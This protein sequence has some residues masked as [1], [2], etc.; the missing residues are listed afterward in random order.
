MNDHDE[1]DPTLSRVVRVE[2]GWCLVAQDG[3]G[4]RA[5]CTVPVAVGDWVRL[6]AAANPAVVDVMERRTAVTRRDPAGLTQVLAANVDLVFVAAP[7]DRYSA[8][9]VERE[10]TIG[11]DSGATP[12]VLLTKADLD[13]GS[14][15]AEL[16]ER[17]VGVDVHPLSASTGQGLDTVSALLVPDRTAVLLG[18]S[19][20]GKSTLVNA[21]LGREATPTREVRSADHRGRH[22]TTFRELHRVPSGGF[23]IDTPG[24]RSLSLTVDEDAVADAFPD[25]A[26]LA[27]GCRFRDCRHGQEPGCAVIE[28]VASGRLSAARLDSYRKIARELDY[29]R[30]RD[31]PVAAREAR[32]VWKARSKAARQFFKERGST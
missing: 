32:A 17:L 4:A 6:S 30:R 21:L 13:D 26:G 3:G 23:L 10:V 7:A 29:E 19:G 14:A 5:R 25:I 20:A 15:Q 18:P 8:G 31:D 11:W 22:S 24:L 9:R 2:H 1:A 28:A 27:A 16:A 12:V